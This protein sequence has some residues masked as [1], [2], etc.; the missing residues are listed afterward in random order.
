MKHLAA[1]NV[2][3]IPLIGKLLFVFCAVGVFAAD[4]I[5][6]MAIISSMGVNESIP[7]LRDFF[8]LTLIYNTG[9]SFG[10]LQDK[11]RIFI[12]MNV[13]IIVFI[14][15]VVFFSADITV[16]GRALLGLIAGGAAGN[17]ADR[18]Q[19]GAVVDF[20]DF[21]GIWHYIFNVADM[22]VV[23]A[24]ILFALV[25]ILSKEAPAKAKPK[26]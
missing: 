24:G 23:C 13:L 9:A 4:Q 25:I 14:S 10:L 15:L 19:Y 12:V 3:R 22:A 11:S 5:S 1:A 20:L 7:V 8:H 2:N 16:A 6:K 18:L 21:R 17:V 26:H